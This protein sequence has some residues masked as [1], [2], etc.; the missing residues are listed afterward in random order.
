MI[1]VIFVQWIYFLFSSLLFPTIELRF[2]RVSVLIKPHNRLFLF[3]F[4]FIFRTIVAD[5]HV[6]L[7]SLLQYKLLAKVFVTFEDRVLSTSRCIKDSNN[8]NNNACH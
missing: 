7:C 3:D 4:G 8:T 5:V 1:I 6:V 2:M